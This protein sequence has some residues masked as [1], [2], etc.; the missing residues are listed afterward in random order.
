MAT[1]ILESEDIRVRVATVK[2]FVQVAQRCVELNN[3]NTSYAIHAAFESSPV[4]RLKKT[5]EQFSS[6]KKNR[7]LVLENETM[8]TLFSPKGNHSNYRKHLHTINP[9]VV[10]YLGVYLTDLT[11]IEDGNS[12]ML[13][14]L[15]DMF[16]NFDKRRKISKSITEIK[17]YQQIPYFLMNVDQ[18]QE[19]LLGVQGIDEKMLYKRSLVGRIRFLFFL[20]FFFSFLSFFFFSVLFSFTNCSSLFVQWSQ[21]KSKCLEEA[22]RASFEPCVMFCFSKKRKQT[23]HSWLI[24]ETNISHTHAD[25]QTAVTNKRHHHNR[26]HCGTLLKRYEMDSPLCALLTASARVGLMS[27]ILS[28][29][30]STP[31]GIGIVFV[32]RI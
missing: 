4:H 24:Q 10:P 31:G 14:A 6:D 11:F 22:C 18:I 27:M 26:A 15:Q 12:D 17:M 28:L 1:K 19:F 13:P 21:R 5:W 23:S 30:H 8:S 16:I 32:T 7:Q 29:L 25:Q 2:F 3:F 20:F 9:P